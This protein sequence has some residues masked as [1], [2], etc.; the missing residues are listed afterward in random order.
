M[1]EK[2]LNWGVHDTHCCKIHGCKYGDKDCPVENGLSDGVKECESCFFDKEEVKHFEKRFRALK[3]D[4]ENKT[5]DIFDDVAKLT[6]KIK[7][8]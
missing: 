4:F 2:K 6:F 1:T 3:V 8:T 5:V 7:L